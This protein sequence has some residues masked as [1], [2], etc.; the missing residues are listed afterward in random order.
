MLIFHDGGLR[1][2]PDWPFSRSCS[3][4][5]CSGPLPAVGI[6]RQSQGIY[7][8]FAALSA[9]LQEQRAAERTKHSLLPR[10]RIQCPQGGG[11]PLPKGLRGGPGVDLVLFLSEHTKA[12]KTWVTGAWAG[13][14]NVWRVDSFF[15]FSIKKGLRQ[16]GR[17]QHWGIFQIYHHSSEHTGQRGR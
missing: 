15:S 13:F 8:G 9:R 6:L 2:N 3:R 10:C 1:F 14:E 11:W 16:G 4:Q 5:R 12:V 7:A 17:F